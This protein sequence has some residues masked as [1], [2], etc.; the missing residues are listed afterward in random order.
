MTAGAPSLAAPPRGSRRTPQPAIFG[1][2]RPRIKGKRPPSP[3]KMQALRPD[4]CAARA[5]RRRA[6][7]GCSQEGPQPPDRGPTHM[8][9]SLSMWLSPP[10]P[11]VS[12]PRLSPGR[13][14]ET[15]ERTRRRSRC[16]RSRRTFRSTRP[17]RCASSTASRCRPG[18]D[19]SLKI[20]GTLR[21][22]GYTGC[23]SW[24]ATLYPVKDQHLAVGPYAL[25]K[26]QC[27]K[28]VMAIEFGFLSGAAR[29]PDLG[30]GQRRPRDQGTARTMR[31]ARSL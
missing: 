16:R 31:L 4:D 9:K 25:T 6:I 28:D 18:L 10:Q 12:P 2:S 5:I 20:D 14:P 22:S 29:Q 24:S 27:D 3:Q 26:K 7:A 17:G 23:N 8:M 30:S 21:G 19:A 11:C 15:E 13:R 1:R